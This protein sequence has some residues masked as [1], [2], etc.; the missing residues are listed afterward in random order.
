[1]SGRLIRFSIYNLW[2][3]KDVHLR[4]C[5]NNLILVGENG[6]GKTT[7]LRM[8]YETLACKWAMLSVEDFA[9]IEIVFENKHPISI[10]KS[11]IQDA[12]ELLVDSDSALFRELPPVIKRT[13]VDRSNLS[14]RDISYDQVI[15]VLDEYDYNDRELIARIKEKMDIIEK[16]TLLEYTNML[17]GSLGCNVIYLPTYRRVEKRIGYINEREYLR[18]RPSYNYRMAN[19]QFSD[20]QSI[21]IAKTGMDDVEYFIQLCLDDIRRKADISASR[22]NYQCFKGILNK[23]SDKVSY[24][25]SILSE[26]EI[27]KVFG[28]IN[29]DVLSPEESFQIQQLLKTMKSTDAPQQQTYEQIVYYFYSM[30][31][32]RYLQ[33][34]ENEKVIL[35]FFEACNAYLSNKKISYNEKEYRYDIFVTDG[36]HPRKIELENLSSGEKQVVSIFSYLYLS[37]LS[38]SI[39]LI[40]EPELSLSVPWQKKF[41]LD[42]S[43]GT[44]CAGIISVTHSP[45]VFDNEL[46]PFAH[47]L[48]EF[49]Q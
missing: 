27:E 29:K 20:E 46:K 22:L 48:E 24:N 8:L 23:T 39:I 38:K 6:S 12:K 15:E 28:S 40:D 36:K 31:H 10:E 5:D 44:Q 19:R 11:K 37:P 35:T 47:A 16:R 7:I 9:S 13:L 14:G 34:K 3:E 45:F 1:M 26:E 21:E 18:R 32:D 43:K 2:G 25:T 17:K 33:I 30:L 42:I 49:I 41:L 4:F